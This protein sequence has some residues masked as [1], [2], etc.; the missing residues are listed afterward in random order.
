[1]MSPRVTDSHDRSTGARRHGEA[2]AG[3][4]TLPK[5]TPGRVV[6]LRRSTSLPGTSNDPA[7]PPRPTSLPFARVPVRQPWRPAWPPGGGVRPARTGEVGSKELTAH[8][9]HRVPPPARRGRARLARRRGPLHPSW[10]PPS[11]SPSRDKSF[12]GVFSPVRQFACSPGRPHRPA[13]PRRPG[14]ASC[15][16][17]RS[18]ASR[19]TLVQLGRQTED[20]C[21]RRSRPTYRPGLTR[22][23]S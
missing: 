14:K 17:L 7:P 4:T 2:G 15:A 1:M 22:I 16:L 12:D 6:Y 23:P 10:L 13:P 3:G 21:R 19:T 18:A 20:S 8:I 5:S 9:D 11:A